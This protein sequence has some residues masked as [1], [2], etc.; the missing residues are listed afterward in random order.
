M[1]SLYENQL[2]WDWNIYH[3]DQARLAL[4]VN[5][6]YCMTLFNTTTLHAG[7]WCRGTG[8]FINSVT[9]LNRY[10]KFISDHI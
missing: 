10:Q 8:C 4:F 3:T 9:L 7:L 1:T 6:A 5:R 2:L